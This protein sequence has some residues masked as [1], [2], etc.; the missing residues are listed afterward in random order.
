MAPKPVPGFVFILVTYHF[1][2]RCLTSLG[3][4]LSLLVRL[5]GSSRTANAGFIRKMRMGATAVVICL[6]CNGR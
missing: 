4:R 3:T 6:I 2:T 1:H 5:R